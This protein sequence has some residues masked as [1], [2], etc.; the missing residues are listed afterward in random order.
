M[1]KLRAPFSLLLL[2][3]SLVAA[4]AAAPPQSLEIESSENVEFGFDGIGIATNG[5]VIKSAGA[6]LTAKQASINQ[7]TGDIFAE[8]SVRIQREDQTWTGEHLHY[9]F[10]TG[11]IDGA[12]F[13][14]G[15]SPIFAAG[16]GLAGNPTN[17]T[18]T[19]TN[20]FITADD[21]SNPLFKVRA[22]YL[23]I[24]PGEYFEARQGTLYAGKVPLFYF[25]YYRR[26][27]GERQ[28]NFSFLP[29]YR[30]SFGPYLLGSYNW[31]WSEN[32][33]GA[34]HADWR[35]KH[36]VGFGPDFNY[37]SGNYG[38][39]TFKYYYT[40]DD[41]PGVDSGGQPIPENR[42]RLYFSYD[43][44]L[45]TNLTVKSQVAYW[46]DPLITHDFFESEY[47]KDIQPKTFVE[48]NQLW[49]NWSLDAVAQPRVN[50]FFETVERLPDVRL[51]GFRQ[52]I[53]ETPLFYESESSAGWFRHVFPETNT[54]MLPF[55]AARADTYHQITLPETFFGWLNVTPRV[56]GR[57]TYYSEAEGTG[58]TTTEHNRSVFNTGAE[59]STKASRTWAG[60]QNHL[61]DVD[62]LRHI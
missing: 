25:P 42:Q 6:V 24:V 16:E 49:Q 58:A 36:G 7:N 48:V 60:V 13:R 47:R 8:G 19:A 32:L 15:M 50:D 37:H 27:L 11:Q 28:S 54:T 17:N 52:Q 1:I 53:G 34:L 56:G 30:S 18:Y 12:Q 10:Q 20:V 3:I 45:R 9:N 38:D 40:R 29:G 39:G 41:N 21:Y 55:S 57:F 44:A 22:K 61:F 35:E 31:F 62:G 59:I 33:E 4:Q 51:T 14:T 46:S 2:G 23:K 5:V 26:P 43:A